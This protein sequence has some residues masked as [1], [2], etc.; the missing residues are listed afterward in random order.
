MNTIKIAA[1][2]VLAGTLIAPAFAK[3]APIERLTTTMPDGKPG[4]IL[5]GVIVPAGYETF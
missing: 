3:P 4:M 5:K 1:A 2:A